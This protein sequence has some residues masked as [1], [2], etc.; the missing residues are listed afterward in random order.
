MLGPHDM[1]VP[2]GRQRSRRELVWVVVIA[3]LVVL[4]ATRVW[5]C[6]AQQRS[7]DQRRAEMYQR[8]LETARSTCTPP[9]PGLESY[10]RDQATLLLE[11]P[12]CDPACVA[13]ARRIRGE[14][15]R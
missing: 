5:H 10:C 15:T 1:A 6:A 4:A 12:E 7:P 9:K 14:P 3:L 8:T 13:L 11:F 2:A